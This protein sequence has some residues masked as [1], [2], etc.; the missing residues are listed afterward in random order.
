M[1]LLNW[2]VCREVCGQESR[3]CESRDGGTGRRSGLKI[4][5]PETV[6]GVRVP[7]SAPAKAELSQFLAGWT[8][9]EELDW[10]S[11]LCPRLCPFC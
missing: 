9:L 4:R 8:S 3:P 1:K 2:A 7:L 5:G 10:A 11:E 6:V